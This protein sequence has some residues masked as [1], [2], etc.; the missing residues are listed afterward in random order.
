MCNLKFGVGLPTYIAVPI[1]IMEN[2][3]KFNIRKA[4]RSVETALTSSPATRRYT[5]DE[6]YVHILSSEH[7]TK[8]SILRK[9]VKK[10]KQ[11]NYK[12]QI[13]LAFEKEVESGQIPNMSYTTSLEFRM[14]LSK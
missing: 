2:N 1:M 13:E 3:S 5:S 9:C 14:F 6:V 11:T 8:Q 7:G 10:F 12:G 4:F